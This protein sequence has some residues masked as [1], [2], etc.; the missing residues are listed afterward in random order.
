MPT[1]SG[2]W[3]CGFLEEREVC[4]SCINRILLY[5]G[6]GSWVGIFG[7]QVIS[8]AIVAA[9]QTVDRA[10]HLHVCTLVLSGPGFALT[11]FK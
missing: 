3:I 4:N 10:F 6:D 8:Q 5:V 11:E 2:L 1:S 7:G 9:T